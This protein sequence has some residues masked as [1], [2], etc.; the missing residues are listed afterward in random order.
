MVGQGGVLRTFSL[1]SDG[2]AG[3]GVDPFR[4]FKRKRG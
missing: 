4:R 3:Y 1:E 2:A